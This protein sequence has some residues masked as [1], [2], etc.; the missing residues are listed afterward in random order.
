MAECK[1]EHEDQVAV[2]HERMGEPEPGLCL[3]VQ[4][5][6]NVA[7][8]RASSIEA[9]TQNRKESHCPGGHL[10]QFALAFAGHCDGCG[11]A[12]KK[13][14]V[15]MDCRP[16]NWYLCTACQPVAECPK[17][18]KL[19]AVVLPPDLA[20]RC[21]G[22]ERALGTGSLAMD[23]REC[24][25]Y[26]CKA[27]NPIT[28]CTAGHSLQRWVTEGVGRCDSCTKEVPERAMVMDCRQCDWYVCAA[29][30]PHNVYICDG[31]DEEVAPLPQCSSGHTLRPRLS[32]P[33][34]CDRCS[35]PVKSKEMVSACTPCNWYVCT[36]CHPIKQ[37]LR[38]HALVSKPADEGTCDGCG[39]PVRKDE[40]VMDCK[41]CNWYLCA[42]CHLPRQ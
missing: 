10:L 21:D 24:N 33:G 37:C 32:Q 36:T 9:T 6:L 26:L 2:A 22:C 14:G 13:G 35:R 16:C 42:M 29:C 11:Q 12:V 7:A 3:K 31:A 39:K 41:R 30:V 40:S 4:E 23:C 27:C 5:Q 38:G 1:A 8:P 28:T 17:A 25:W 34:S 15:V 19:K 20:G 18:H